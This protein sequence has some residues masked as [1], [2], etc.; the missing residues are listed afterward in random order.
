M[1]KNW[2]PE[3]Q[4]W[5]VTK[6]TGYARNTKHHNERQVNALAG[7]ISAYGFVVPILADS[8]GIIIAGHC[9][10]EAAKK[11]G[12]QEVPV[13]VADHLSEGEVRALRLADN[14]LNESPWDTD[15]LRF[16]LKGL[17]DMGIDLSLAAFGDIPDITK[18]IEDGKI[19]DGLFD[20]PRH[21]GE[22]QPESLEVVEGEDDVPEVHEKLTWVKPGDLWT[23]GKHRLLCGDSTDPKNFERVLAGEKVD[24]IW[25]DPPYGVDMVA[26]NK[27]LNKAT[28]QSSLTS[29][30]HGDDL[31]V[32][33]LEP[34]IRAV[35]CNINA[36]LAHKSSYYVCSPQGGELGLMMMMMMQE[37]G[38]QCRHM[39]IWVKNAPVFS[40][41]RLDYDYQHEPILYGWSKKRVHEFHG[42][43]PFTKSIWKVDRE[44]N[45]LHPTMKPIALVENALLNSSLSGDVVMDP[46]GGGGS[47]LIA[48][49]K[50]NR[51]ARLIEIDPHY[52]GIILRRF[53]EFSGSD[54]VREDGA[55]LSELMEQDADRVS[56]SR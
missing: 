21:T 51:R 26:K 12:M 43:G 18:F 28:G 7:S 47:T 17:E 32:D 27:M 54:P 9:R 36:N 39:C 3:I 19:V 2:K 6:L 42:N 53:A 20:S 25:T 49:E 14:R 55:K 10:V 15:M 1:S 52:C 48:A 30:I 31:S 40:M 4:T 41:G 8:Q 33:K 11:L 34:I 5:P 38:I 22:E 16:E 46:F 24:L 35:F 23:L 13:I 50:H 44:P 29:P 37:S 45:K 56:D